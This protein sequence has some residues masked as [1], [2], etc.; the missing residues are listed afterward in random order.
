MSAV[1]PSSDL[2][3][4]KCPLEMDNLHQL[5]FASATA[6]H[7]YFAG[8]P[9]KLNIDDDDY[10]YIR[11]DSV[12]RIGAH[13]DTLLQYNYVMYRNDNY[14]NKWFYAFI[15]DME[16]LNDNCTV[17]TIKTDTWQTWQFD[18]TFKKCFVE[19]EHTNSD[20]IG[21]HTVPENL[22]LGEY[23]CNS[24]TH[25]SYASPS[26]N[27]QPSNNVVICFQVTKTTVGNI[28]FPST[29]NNIITGI[30]QGCS[31]F[32]LQLDENSAGAMAFVTGAYD[33]NGLGDAIVSIFLVPKAVC[34]WDIKHHTV[35]GQESADTWLVPRTSFS[36]VT[37]DS[38]D[39]T[40]N[41][42][43]NG[44]TPK[45]KKLYTYP[46]NYLYVTNNAGADITY[47]YELFSQNEPYFT[48]TGAFEQGGNLILEP[49]NSLTSD[50][51][52]AW[53]AYNEGVPSGKLPC[54]S[55]SSDYYL[56]WKAINGKNVEVQTALTGL[57]FGTGMVMDLAGMAMGDGPVGGTSITGLASN[58]ASTLQQVKQA[59]M[60]PP[61]AKGNV[62]GGDLQFSSDRCGWT[63]RKMS[64]KR[65]YAEIIDN[66]F[67]QVGYK[68]DMVKIPNITGRQNW[69][70]VKTIDINI[71]ADI[72]QADLSEIK[73]MFNR[74][75]T[76]WHNPATF[77][78]Y[79]QNNNIV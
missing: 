24:R 34:Q 53:G 41:S 68:V 54:L 61:Q 8:L 17:V 11:Q 76:I 63:F 7:N 51:N 45:N 23:I 36:A 49:V 18:L 70:Y 31:V 52:T 62:A 3:L 77:L 43:L 2:Y 46:Y 9:K 42:T 72:P 64:I 60:T 16:Y 44:Y 48:V 79:S 50:T 67:S 13:I 40:I 30:P 65:E 28:V 47:H 6:Q 14:S 59:K 75:V 38:I 78:D 33:N 21:E 35:D 4:L 39:V 22:E 58:L 15:T 74:G 56:N 1:T 25:K 29:A 69:N 12:L 71:L 55:W 5:N 10:S 66:Y 37:L 19:R 73:Q 26:I 27:G 20:N 57:S 32:G